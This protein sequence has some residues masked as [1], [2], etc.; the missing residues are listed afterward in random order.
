MN[1]QPASPEADVA[2]P[3]A[4]KKA[5]AGANE[6]N[7]SAA[8]AVACSFDSVFFAYP[9]RPLAPVLNGLSLEVKTGE[10]VAVV[11]AS[12]GGK[13]TLFNL[14]LRLYDPSPGSV[15]INGVDA[16]AMDAKTLR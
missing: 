10:T 8:S 1:R 6:I 12:G 14:L 3:V 7:S 13:S 5:V 2:D 4:K 9:A 11:G 15:K 16:A